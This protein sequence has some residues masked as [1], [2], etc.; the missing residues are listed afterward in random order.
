MVSA[1]SKKVIG[2][3]TLVVL[4]AAFGILFA[5]E[6]APSIGYMGLVRYLCMAAGFVLFA[7]SFVGFAIMLVVSSQE[8]KGGAGAGFAATAARFAREVAR[9]ASPMRARPSWRSA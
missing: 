7:L 4:F 2:V 5:G 3:V 6:W 9:L 8:R 1:S